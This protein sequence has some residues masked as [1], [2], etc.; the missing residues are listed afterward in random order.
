MFSTNRGSIYQH[1][2]DTPPAVCP[3]TGM[4]VSYVKISH[5]YV[6]KLNPVYLVPL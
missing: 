6:C 1:S 4:Y 5:L 3:M 2:P